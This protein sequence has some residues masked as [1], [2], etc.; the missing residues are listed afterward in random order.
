MF[1]HNPPVLSLCDSN[2]YLKTL[3][4]NFSN[5]AGTGIQK[6]I[7]QKY[8]RR[9]SLCLQLLYTELW[10]TNAIRAK[11]DGVNFDSKVGFIFP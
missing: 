3:F 2:V 11:L 8:A 7:T 6:M 4:T 5:S 10:A 9:A 1:L